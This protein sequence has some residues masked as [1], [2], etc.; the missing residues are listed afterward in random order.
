MNALL[1]RH[2]TT[3][4]NGTCRPALP[5]LGDVALD[6]SRAHEACGP[7]RHMLAMLVA[8]AARGPVL[9]IAP[10]WAQG[11]LNTDAMVGLAAPERFVFAAPGRAEDVL[12]CVEEALRSGA[13]PLVIAE[14]PAPP[15]LTAVRRMHLA[16]E[17]GGQG[18]GLLLT[19]GAGGAPG[20]ETRWHMAPAHGPRTQ[21]WTLT[22]LRARTAPPRAWRLEG[23]AGAWRLTPTPMPDAADG[24][25]GAP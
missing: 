8:G 16:A 14:L 10:G 21:R 23:A 9:W 7:A 5:V 20:I 4:R 18:L 2:P 11:G 15:G 3:T 24:S 12:W 13:A 17:A 6:L 1:T 25:K 19:P 22:R